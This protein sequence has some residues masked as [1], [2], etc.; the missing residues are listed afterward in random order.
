[1]EIT[2]GLNST[3]CSMTVMTS[4]S[5]TGWWETVHGHFEVDVVQEDSDTIQ[6]PPLLTTRGQNV[7]RNFFVVVFDDLWR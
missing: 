1:M 4:Y 6:L 3:N 2:L 7:S 5:T